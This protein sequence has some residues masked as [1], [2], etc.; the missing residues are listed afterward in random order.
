MVAAEVALP[1][2]DRGISEGHIPDTIYG[3]MLTVAE[4]ER[5]KVSFYV[6]LPIRSLDR[7]QL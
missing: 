6:L 1:V 5:L 3:V 4:P 7:T 2:A